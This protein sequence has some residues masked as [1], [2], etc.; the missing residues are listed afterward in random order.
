MKNMLLSISLYSRRITKCIFGCL[1]IFEFSCKKY[2]AGQQPLVG[3][4]PP[5]FTPSIEVTLQGDTIHLSTNVAYSVAFQSSNLYFYVLSADE[6]TTGA[7]FR[8]EYFG[9]PPTI[10]YTWYTIQSI[11]LSRADTTYFN[12]SNDGSVD[13]MS[14]SF[15]SSIS[16]AFGAGIYTDQAGPHYKINGNFQFL[17]QH[18]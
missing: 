4:N 10:T 1:L 17:K 5:T 2:I 18:Q 16:G 15:E 14:G 3:D 6:A 11:S 12:Y 13:I 9:G 7:H 8:L